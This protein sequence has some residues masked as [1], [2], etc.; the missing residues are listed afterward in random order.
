[1]IIS[2]RKRC[3]AF[4]L[5]EIILVVFIISL[6]AGISI[7]AFSNHYSMMQ[8]REKADH[9][10]HL[11]RYAQSRAILD[12]KHYFLYYDNGKHHVQ[13]VSYNSESEFYEKMLSRWGRL[14]SLESIQIKNY[15]D[16]ISFY[17]DGR[18]DPVTL[19]LFYKNNKIILTTAEQR[20]IVRVY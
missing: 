12:R 16:Q 6:I 20:G 14:V 10:A 8:L 5:I 1:M 2:L 13:I 9:I 18:I 3:C 4:T 7:P 17:P 15:P 19:E 11:M